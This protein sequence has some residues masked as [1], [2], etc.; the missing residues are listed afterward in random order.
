MNIHEYQ[1]KEIFKNNNINTLDG[2][3]AY[4]SKEAV[5]IAKDLNCK[6]WVVKA[7][8]H[9]GGRGKGGGIKVAHSLEELKSY[10]ENMIGMNLVTPQTGS[11]GKKV[12]IFLEILPKINLREIPINLFL[13]TPEIILLKTNKREYEAPSVKPDLISTKF[14]NNHLCPECVNLVKSLFSICTD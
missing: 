10:A 9:A 7:Q 8:I 6:S 13:K 14:L 12:S 5:E 1:A 11:Q 2:K 3:V 4:S